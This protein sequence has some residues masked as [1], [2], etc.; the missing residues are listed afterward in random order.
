VVAPL[1]QIDI[2][3]KRIPVVQI[4]ANLKDK[5]TRLRVK[6]NWSD[7]PAKLIT[8][9]P[10]SDIKDATVGFLQDVAK[11]GG[12]FSQG[13]LKGFGVFFPAREGQKK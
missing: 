12:Q 13:M 6:G 9:E 3:L 2:I 4:V 11:T 7:P 10:I 1:G 5:L 8:K